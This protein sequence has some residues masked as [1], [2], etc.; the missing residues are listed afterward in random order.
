MLFATQVFN[1]VFFL[2]SVLSFY[3]FRGDAFGYSVA[4]VTEY[5][6][7]GCMMYT[8]MHD[9][10]VPISH[11]LYVL[12][13]V[14]DYFQTWRSLVGGEGSTQ[15]FL[16]SLVNNVG[17]LSNVTHEVSFVKR[18]FFNTNPIENLFSIL[19]SHLPLPTPLQFCILW[20]LK[21][22]LSGLTQAVLFI[23]SQGAPHTMN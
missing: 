8:V 16:D 10:T 20:P 11:K 15:E 6:R 13:S 17:E 23:I 18:E 14:L 12:H 19:K 9:D 22:L 21:S 5:L 2:D 3:V 7:V 4:A 1:L